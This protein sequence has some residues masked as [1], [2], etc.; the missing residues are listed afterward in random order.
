MACR[1]LQALHYGLFACAVA[2]LGLAASPSTKSA[3][4]QT[5]PVSIAF[6]L[7]QGAAKISVQNFGDSPL[8]G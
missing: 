1:F 3:D 4:L 7:V 8:Y 6:D 2:C 5:S